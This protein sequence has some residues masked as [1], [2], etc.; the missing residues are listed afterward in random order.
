MT[1]T[2][3]RGTYAEAEQAEKAVGWLG[4]AAI[5]LVFAGGWN[6]FDGI[7]AIAN[8]K[9]FTKNATYVFSD[10]KTWGWIILLLGV[11]ELLRVSQSWVAA[12]S[13]A[14]SASSPPA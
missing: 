1:S 8:S 5:M 3:Q 11:G 12:S 9:V 7:L 4:Y 6:I 2:A 14:G 10:L 13:G